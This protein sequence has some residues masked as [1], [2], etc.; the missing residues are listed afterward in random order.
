MYGAGSGFLELLLT[1]TTIHQGPDP[2][3]GG[4]H[5][6]PIQPYVNEA[7]EKMRGGGFAVCLITDGDAD[8]IGCV[9][10]K[11]NYVTSHQIFALLLKHLVENKK[12][13]GKV[14]KSIS[15]TKMIDRLCQK[16]GLPLQVTPIGFKVISPAMKE[17]D[18]LIGGEESGGIGMPYHLCERD[19]LLCGLLLLE[20]MATQKMSMG[21]LVTALQKEAG[22]S[23]Y[24][25]SD[26]KLPKEQT[27]A[28]RQKL[29]GFQPKELAG[30]RV[31]KIDKID[32][33][34]FTLE[35]ESWLLIRP[36]GTEPLLRTYA[37][38]STM[39]QVET[40]LNEAKLV[41]A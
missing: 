35:D 21:E 7:M 12:R 18:V 36:S 11:G 15:T 41:I 17:G 16:Y 1:V 4:I 20:L 29:K 32:G 8:R 2:N 26:L 13:K 30:R 40:L 5:P 37:E 10:E 27:E 19:G 39:T 3:F 34:H 31:K 33:Y 14:V 9:D 6:E 24:K 23:F 28:V 38:A 22:P 25:R